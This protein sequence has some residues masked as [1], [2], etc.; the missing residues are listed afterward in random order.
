MPT[1]KSNVVGECC[2]VILAVIEKESYSCPLENT[3][4][5]L[6]QGDVSACATVTG[7]FSVYQGVRKRAADGH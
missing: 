3:K 5:W 1:L 2:T 4:Q 6:M 7:V